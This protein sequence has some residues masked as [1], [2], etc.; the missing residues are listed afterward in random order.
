VKIKLFCEGKTEKGLREL[1]RKA[2][3]Q[4]LSKPCGLKIKTFDGVANL[5]KGIEGKLKI[6]FQ[7]GAKVIYLLVDLYRYPNIE[8][9][10]LEERVKNVKEDIETKLGN[11]REGV[12]IFVIIHEVETWILADSKAIQKRLKSYTPEAYSNLEQ[13][14]KY[15]QPSK[16]LNQIFR[17][18]HP[19][20][21]GYE[22]A[23][24][25]VF[26][27]ENV[28][29]RMVYATCTVFK[30]LVDALRDDCKQFA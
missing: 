3:N 12:K 21:Y 28:D 5:L 2:V 26:L 25:G 10:T 20:G 14:G 29:W 22:K 9:K 11:R 4:D 17:Q 30:S 24:D 18:H 15:Q 1:L 6:E 23:V 19:K 27:L 13:D 7:E 16:V 8:P